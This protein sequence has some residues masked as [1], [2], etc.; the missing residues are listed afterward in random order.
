[1]DDMPPKQDISNRTN[2]APASSILLVDDEAVI[3]TQLEERLTRMGYSVAGRAASAEEGIEMARRLRPD[4]ILMDIVMPGGMDGIDAT[5]IIGREMGIPVVFLTA[6]G[7]D[8]YIERAKKVNPEG[9]IIKPYQ[10]NEIK[11]VIELVLERRRSSAKRPSLE[12]MYTSAI[13]LM[14]YAA[15][16]LD[17]SGKPI[18]WNPPAARMLGYESSAP[19]QDSLEGLLVFDAAFGS[20]SL[21]ERILSADGG[22]DGIVEFEAEGVRK[23]GEVF[24]LYMSAG[25]VRRPGGRMIVCLAIDISRYKSSEKKM[26]ESILA[27]ELVMREIHHRVKNNFQII[28]SLLNLQSRRMADPALREH[29]SDCQSRVKAM[30]LVHEN[31]HLSGRFDRLD[32]PLYLRS[33][34]RD[35]RRAFS[36]VA[37]P[38]DLREN[39]EPVELYIDQAVPCG[40]I[41]NELLTNAFKYAFPARWKGEAFIEVSLRPAE[42]RRVEIVVRDNGTGLPEGLDPEN[43][44]TLGFSLVHLLVQ[45]LKGTLSI[46][47]KN[48]TSVM[49]GFDLRRGRSG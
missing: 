38:V 7:D 10:E 32:M 12:E 5:E 14:P 23:N 30:A 43:T 18:S 25:T 31:L 9:Y 3:T 36:G 8:R 26:A 19:V 35:I 13:S 2:I 42:E 33:M 27:M 41:V 1:M 16:L 21:A 29:L 28:V 17:E 22:E 20:E 15:F 49:F 48:G 39:F 4:L 34:V 47:R 11:A 6:Y 24:P 46:G 45:Q 37:R 40:I 44:A